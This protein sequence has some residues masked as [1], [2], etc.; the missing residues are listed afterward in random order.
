MHNTK[1]WRKKL[2]KVLVDNGGS[3]NIIDIETL[4][5]ISKVHEISLETTEKFKNSII[6][7]FKRKVLKR[8]KRKI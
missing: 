5:K 8:I 3:V 6:K 2:S 1:N 4:E 7:K